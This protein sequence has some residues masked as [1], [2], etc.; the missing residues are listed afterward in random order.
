MDSITT[1]CYR[2][3]GRKITIRDYMR[4]AKNWRLRMRAYNWAME[5]SKKLKIV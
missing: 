5:M 3:S 1:K 2:D 4:Y